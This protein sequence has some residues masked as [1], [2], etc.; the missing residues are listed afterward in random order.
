MEAAYVGLH[1][2]GHAHSIECWQ[3]LPDGRRQL[4]GGLL[5]DA[6]LLGR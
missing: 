1:D 6:Q 5:A 4:V 3:T 2:Q